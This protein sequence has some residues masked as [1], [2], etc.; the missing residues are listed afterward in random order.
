MKIL[1]INAVGQIKST[2]R[3]CREL[4]QHINQLEGHSCYTAF[5]IGTEDEFGYQIGNKRDAKLHALL[6][7]V[8]GKQAYFSKGATKKLISYMKDLQPDVV[9][10]R[11]LHGNYIHFPMLMKY[12][13]EEDIPT[14]VTLHDCWFFTGKC[15]HYTV[16]GCY[17]WQTGCH[18]CS[19]RKKDNT[20]WLFD[21]T[22]KLWKEKKQLFEAIPRL[23]V[24]GVS[25]WVVDEAGKSFLRCAKEI[26]RIYNWIDL[27]VFK[28][29]ESAD[30][31][32]AR[33]VPEGKKVI[34]GIASDWNNA[35]GLE[36]F[37]ALANRLGDDYRICLV[38]LLPRKIQ[39]PENVIC[40]EP[41]NS[42]KELAQLYTMAD[43]FV[44]LS[45][46][47][48]F[49]KVSAEALACGTP[50]VCYD[51]TANKELVGPG[52]GEVHRLNDLGAV[53]ASVKKI[54]AQDKSVYGEACRAF[55]QA[56]FKKEDRIQDY[57]D[58]Y[59]RIRV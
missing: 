26:T 12:L 14:V 49:S 17:K 11:N 31:L 16:D 29:Q 59:E 32:R 23:A 57:L 20:S 58:L 48:T 54:C 10:L 4:A 8:T 53:E 19:R 52:C 56:T 13:A 37:M 1:Q 24:T 38:G 30:Q 9:H 2:G 45:P 46:E 39:M 51:S 44:S 21:R 25:Q 27:S 35:K 15:C 22:K 55:V 6:S 18:H 34:L 50:V 28:P 5:S 36:Q 3:T 7:R 33:L 43:V 42:E 41:T 40:I 47:E